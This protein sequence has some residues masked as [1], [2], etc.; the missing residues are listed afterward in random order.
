[1]SRSYKEDVESKT[2][3][4]LIIRLVGIRAEVADESSCSRCQQHR[5]ALR[6]VHLGLNEASVISTQSL[7]E[8]RTYSMGANVD[9][10]EG[11]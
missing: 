7:K 9:G 1:M 11:S 10:I 3:D 5:R 6:V 2:S 8:V 4:N